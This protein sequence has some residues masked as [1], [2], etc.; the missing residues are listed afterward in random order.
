MTTNLLK[1]E[2]GRITF[3]EWNKVTTTNY[4]DLFKRKDGHFQNGSFYPSMLVMH[5]SEMNPTG[6]I[7]TYADGD[8]I[9]YGPDT[10]AYTT[11]YQ[12][13]GNG[14]KDKINAIYN[15]LDERLP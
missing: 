11:S 6:F 4:L 15:S 1:D 2:H 9:F 13:L 7:S 12:K 10:F 5:D 3:W 14:D 8:H